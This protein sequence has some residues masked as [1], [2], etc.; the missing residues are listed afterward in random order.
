MNRIQ[1]T[2]QRPFRL[3]LFLILVFITDSLR[4]EARSVQ[5][6]LKG[7]IFHYFLHVPETYTGKRQFPLFI[8]V[9]AFEGKGTEVATAFEDAA[10]KYEFILVCPTFEGEYMKIENSED[11]LL[12]RII[13]EVSSKYKLQ[14]KVFLAG[15]LSGADFIL[16]FTTQHAMLVRGASLHAPISPPPA[17]GRI[18]VP[19]SISAGMKHEQSYKNS[20]GIGEALTDANC[21]VK[22]LFLE[23]SG[24]EW[25]EQAQ[26]LCI[27]TYLAVDAGIALEKRKEIEEAL[28]SGEELMAQERYGKAY[29]VLKRAPKAG[30]RSYYTNRKKAMIAGIE[31]DGLA[32]LKSTLEAVKTP[33]I[34]K[35]ELRKLDAMFAGTKAGNRIRA[36]MG[37][38]R[39]SVKTN[40]GVGEAISVRDDRKARSTLNNG[41]LLADAGKKEAATKYLQ[42]VIDQYPGSKYAA[43]A[44]QLLEKMGK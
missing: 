29:S 12:M 8:G 14:K 32:R 20:Q 35:A 33:A 10:D 36:V 43:E 40:S 38:V 30:P 11:L 1:S 15:P 25:T 2:G 28:Q 22:T 5:V 37:G 4:A 23:D 19:F 3:C 13:K 21:S 7:T 44:K 42:K 39:V 18:G 26:K 16:N 17:M 24:L 27:E 9:H 6:N 34:L 41:K 31:R